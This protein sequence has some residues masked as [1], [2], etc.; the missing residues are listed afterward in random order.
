MSVRS[1]SELSTNLEQFAM[2][3]YQLA[4]FPTLAAAVVALAGAIQSHSEETQAPWEISRSE[5]ESTQER[6][7]EP[8]AVAALDR[9]ISAL[10][11]S[12]VQWMEVKVWQQ[13]RVDGRSYQAKGRIVAAPGDRVR[14]DLNVAVGGT[15]AEL[16]SVCSRDRLWQSMKLTG[17]KAE[18]REM[19]VPAE[20]LAFLRA[21]G[22][23]GLSPMLQALR[24]GQRRSRLIR[25]RWK[26]REVVIVTGALPDLAPDTVADGLAFGPGVAVRHFRL[27]LD[28]KDSWP[29]RM[30]W[31]GR[32]KP[33]QPL[34]LVMQT[35]FRDPV[36][37]RPL[38]AER[39]R[40]EFSAPW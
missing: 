39:Q 15:T 25:A 29:Y 14:F 8:A 37:N 17:E 23:A 2:S 18:I 31:W 26:N 33:G 32:E 11:P 13:S 30:E 21:N 19:V 6:V 9:A 22:F 34:R 4:L 10:D 27:Y 16:R 40:A 5:D 20:R 24:E 28:A 35:E 38:S 1:S 7:A 12:R 3:R 36:L